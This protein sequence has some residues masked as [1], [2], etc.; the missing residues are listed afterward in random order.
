MTL[1]KLD[2]RTLMFGGA[3][4][5]V[6]AVLWIVL[7]AERQTDIVKPSDT[8]PAAAK[9]L[10]GVGADTLDRMMQDD[11]RIDVAA[12]EDLQKGRLEFA[13]AVLGSR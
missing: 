9:K 11:Q 3:A 10:Y 7:P 12:E 2:R 13:D 5:F 8:I 4:L 1:G 6:C